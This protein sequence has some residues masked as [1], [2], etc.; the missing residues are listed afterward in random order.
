MFCFFVV[1]IGVEHDTQQSTVSFIAP[2]SL[3]TKLRNAKRQKD[4]RIDDSESIGNIRVVQ[5]LND[6]LSIYGG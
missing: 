1:T 4:K 2:K 6:T 5:R 3:E